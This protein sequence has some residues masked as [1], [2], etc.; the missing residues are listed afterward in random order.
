M[1]AWAWT[2]DEID[3]V[4][5]CLLPDGTLEMRNPNEGQS[6]DAEKKSRYQYRV[7]DGLLIERR[8]PPESVGDAWRDTGVPEW[9]IIEYPAH[10]G[11]L[12]DYWQSHGG[13][14]DAYLP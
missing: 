11:L 9:A 14:I 3:G 4:W 13:D 2:H 12:R 5:N 7:V 10:V 6:W 8:L 1:T